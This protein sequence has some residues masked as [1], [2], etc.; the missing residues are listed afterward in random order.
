[1]TA[2][3]VAGL[4]FTRRIGAGGEAEV[5]E[6]AG[7]ADVVCKHFRQPTPERTAKLRVML[8]HPPEGTRSGGHVSVAWPVELVHDGRSPHAIG[9]LMPRIDVASAVP[10][11]Q[12]YNPATRLRVAPG[13]TWRY[14]LRTARNV[15]AIVDAVH[16][17][18]HVVGD[19]NESNCDSMQITDPATRTIYRST[20]GKPE[21]L[22]PELHGRDLSSTDRTPASDAFALGVLVHQLLLEGVHPHAGVWR[23]RGDPPDVATRVARGWIAGRR[24]WSPVD[25]PPHAVPLS[26]LPADVRRLV[27]RSLSRR[28]A[29]RPQPGEWVDALERLDGALRTC[30]RSP[31]HLYASR[32]C[33]WCARI[34]RGLPD[35]FPGPTGA[36]S[37]TP[38][39]PPL[40]RRLRSLLWSRTALVARFVARA[41]TGVAARTVAVATA[42]AYAGWMWPVVAPIAIALCV[43]PIVY[44]VLTPSRHVIKA[45]NVSAR[46]FVTSAG[47]SAGVAAMFVAWPTVVRAASAVAAVVHGV[48]LPA[49]SPAW[50]KVRQRLRFQSRQVEK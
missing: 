45:L 47:A 23:G 12:V 10:V 11:F 24:G 33:P 27:R 41:V 6:V 39:R 1:M 48:V 8:E 42:A 7:R 32:R 25:R 16:R 40:H 19:L 4:T 22:A 9:F 44:A 28:A 14:L 46:M 50:T 3:G 26:V 20:V 49:S 5:Y 43:L 36:S 18:G 13:F 21:F 15:A 37:L 29:R 38:R 34:D 2:T 35:P 31:H 30:K 17:A